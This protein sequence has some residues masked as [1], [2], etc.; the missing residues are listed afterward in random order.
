M[1]AVEFKAKGGRLRPEQKAFLS[2]V[3]W[4]GGVAFVAHDCRDVLVVLD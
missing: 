2:M 1:L 3:C 4:F